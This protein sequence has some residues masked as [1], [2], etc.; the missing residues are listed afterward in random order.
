MNFNFEDTPEG[1]FI[2]TIMAAQ[3]QLER[4]QNARQVSQKMKARLERG[5]WCFNTTGYFSEKNDLHGKIMRSFDRWA[6]VL[7]E[8]FEGFAEGRFIT[9][10]AVADFIN[11]QKLP[12]TPKDSRP[13]VVKHPKG[14]LENIFYAGY[15]EYPKWNV[16]RRKGHHKGV[17]TLETWL[18]VQDRL[19]GTEHKMTCR[20]IRSEFPL[21]GFLRCAECGRLITSSYSTGRHGGK[22]AYYRCQN[23]KQ[24]CICGGKSM[25]KEEVENLFKEKLEKLKPQRAILNLAEEILRDVWK[26]KMKNSKGRKQELEKEINKVQEDIELYLDRIKST[27]N[28]PILS[29]YEGKIVELETQKEVLKEQAQNSNL[30]NEDFEYVLETAIGFLKNPLAYW[31]K[32]ELNEKLI[33]QKLVF[34]S[35]LTYST[36][37]GFGTPKISL[38]LEVLSKTYSGKDEMVHP[39]GCAF[40]LCT[41]CS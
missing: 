35:G 30:S 2:E 15:V 20:D 28:E 36:E 40:V 17:I 19:N 32:G 33:A 26:D 24:T 29:V 9:Q 5:Y 4:K 23:H 41:K 22:F 3:G 39:E 38:P 7:K 31:S 1:E 34:P 27:K 16:S 13:Y 10:R 8:A 14:L 18:K 11:S 25:K 12:R 21:R 37:R 6:D